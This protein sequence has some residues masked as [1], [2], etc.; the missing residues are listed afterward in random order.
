MYLC[1]LCDSTAESFG[2]LSN[3]SFCR[4][5]FLSLLIQLLC[6][7]VVI[8]LQVLHTHTHITRNQLNS[9]VKENTMHLKYELYLYVSG[10][11]TLIRHNRVISSNGDSV[12]KQSA[13]LGL[14]IET[15]GRESVHSLSN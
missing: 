4:L 15:T 10:D 13:V 7:L 11:E 1:Y 14:F 8:N 12:V 3:L 6:L 2:Q 5:H 9:L